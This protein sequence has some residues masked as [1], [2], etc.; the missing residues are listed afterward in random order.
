[1]CIYAN[2]NYNHC[3]SFENIKTHCQR[4]ISASFGEG[5]RKYYHDVDAMISYSY[6]TIMTM[7]SCKT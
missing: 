7:A 1:M 3:K 6:N 5:I 2:Y 4:F